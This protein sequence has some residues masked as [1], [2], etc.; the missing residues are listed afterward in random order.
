MTKGVWASFGPAGFTGGDHDG[1][2]DDDDHGHGR[3]DD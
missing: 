2:D 3:D 1:D